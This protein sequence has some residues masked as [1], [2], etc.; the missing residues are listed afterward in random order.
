MTLDNGPTRMVLGNHERSDG[1]PEE[2]DG[3]SLRPHPDETLLTERAGSAVVFDD[4]TRHGG[5]H[6]NGG[7][8]RRVVICSF[9]QRSRSQPMVLNNAEETPARLSPSQR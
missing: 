8:P 3:D 7:G 2:M 1:L 9:T 5:S 4:R 6:Q